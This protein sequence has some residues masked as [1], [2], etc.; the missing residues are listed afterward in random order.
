MRTRVW[1]IG[2]G[3]SGLLFAGCQSQEEIAAE[4]ASREAQIQEA[5]AGMAP[6]EIKYE[7]EG[8]ATSVSITMSTPSGTQ[9]VADASVPLRPKSGDGAGLL[10]KMDSGE[11]AY[12]S[13][14]NN[15]DTGTVVCRITVDGKVIAENQS[16]GA[17]VIASCDGSVP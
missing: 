8:T 5:L 13:A 2:V 7:V 11:F 16:S 3:L 1:A 15:G 9:Q 6:K 17:Y 4:S 14:Q 10:V 12:L